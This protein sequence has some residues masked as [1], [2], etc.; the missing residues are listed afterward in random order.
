MERASAAQCIARLS[1]SQANEREEAAREL[2][3][4]GCAAAEPALRNWFANPEFR[5]LIRAGK[6]LLTVGIAV[7]PAHFEQIRAS[8]GQP[9]LAEMPPGHDA[10]EFEIEFAHGVRIDVLTTLSPGGDGAIARFLE[11]FGE[12]IQQVECAVRDVRRATQI[13]RDHFGLEPVSPDSASG[14]ARAGADGTRVNFFLVPVDERRKALI[15]LVE[16]PAHKS[17]KP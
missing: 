5:A 6:P 12:G 1:S 4:Q 16:S 15:E 3:R 9:R 13:L 10:R 11:R 14:D 17:R 8:C 2:F 7:T